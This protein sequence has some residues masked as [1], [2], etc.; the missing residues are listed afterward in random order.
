MKTFFCRNYSHSTCRVDNIPSRLREH[1][2]AYHVTMVM[3]AANGS[4]SPLARGDFELPQEHSPFALTPGT[5]HVQNP[6][7]ESYGNTILTR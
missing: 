6:D 1:F 3:Q 5:F 2:A 7:V 4:F